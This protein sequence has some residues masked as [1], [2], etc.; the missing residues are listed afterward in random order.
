MLTLP[1]ILVCYVKHLLLQTASTARARAATLPNLNYSQ[2]YLRYFRRTREWR[3]IPRGKNCG[4]LRNHLNESFAFVIEKNKPCNKHDK[5][6]IIKTNEQNP[7]FD[8]VLINGLEG[9]HELITLLEKN[10]DFDVSSAAWGAYNSRRDSCTI[11]IDQADESGSVK[12]RERKTCLTVLLR[13]AFKMDSASF[14]FLLHEPDY[15]Y[16][17]D[18]RCYDTR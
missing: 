13:L 5:T 1:F 15:L 17:A 10:I 11:S 4:P 8:L 3:Y 7:Y 6:V 18:N 12:K 14:S 2:E 9:G 16:E